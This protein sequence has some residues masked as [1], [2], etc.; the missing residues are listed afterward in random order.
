M[1]NIS[2]QRKDS[3]L[4]SIAVINS[5]V[6]LRG[7]FRHNKREI[8]KELGVR[9]HID[10]KKIP[11]NYALVAEE[12]TDD[13]VNKVRGLIEIYEDLTG[14]RIR[15]DAVLAIE[16]LFSLP[17]ANTAIV[18]REYFNDCLAWTKVHF[19][20]AEVLTANVH[21]DEANPHMHVILSCVDSN[22]LIGSLLKGNK[23]KYKERSDDFFHTVAQKY[24]L[25]RPNEKLLKA[26]RMR[27]A[28]QVISE[29]ENSADPVTKSLHYQLIRN[30]IEMDPVPFATNLGIEIKTAPKKMRTVAQIFTSKGKGG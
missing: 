18:T 29:V 24:G 1:N 19:S 17:A 23:N 2:T 5:I 12:R 8:Q 10:S 4:F 11:L 14:R 28:K 21:M 27:L 7:A 20:P 30:R 3:F 25:S 9:S 26:D 13:L 6:Q 16:V 22:K 15:R